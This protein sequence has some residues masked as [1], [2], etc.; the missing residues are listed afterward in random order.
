MEK[1]RGGIKLAHPYP[2]AALTS[3]PLTIADLQFGSFQH[4]R[5]CFQLLAESITVSV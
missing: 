1:K 5:I 4:F 3:K 2:Q